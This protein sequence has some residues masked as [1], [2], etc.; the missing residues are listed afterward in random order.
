MVRECLV[1]TSAAR[2]CSVYTIVSGPWKENC[3]VVASR[4]SRSGVIIDPGS[5]VG[6][7]Q[8]IVCEQ[9][10]RIL[11]ILLTHAHYDHVDGLAAIRSRT[12]APVYIHKRDL[13]LLRGANAYAVAW[14]LPV[15]K[16]PA[17]DVLLEGDAELP[18]FDDLAVSV[19]DLPGHTSG[20]V[21]YAMGH[22]LFVGDS[23]LPLSVGRVDLPGGDE[24]LLRAS[25]RKVALWMTEQT[26]LY[27]G[28]GKPASLRFLLENNKQFRCSFEE[29]R[30]EGAVE[31]SSLRRGAP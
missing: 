21:G 4:A 30:S 31:R 26:V 19:L 28:H 15:I 20:S 2:A 5:A 18:L 27:P 10:I 9:R 11:A 29:T 16:I 13:A 8:S 14:R 22:M 24:K 7:I 3:Y 6:R 17:P 23:V 1:R 12:G 25:I